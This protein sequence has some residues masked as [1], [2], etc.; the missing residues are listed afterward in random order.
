MHNSEFD[1][2]VVG[3]GS[4][5]CVLAN[6]LSADPSNRVLLIEAGGADR[7]PYIHMPAGLPKLAANLALNWNY[8]TEPQQGLAGRKLWWPRG[9]V[10]GGSSSINAMCYIRGQRED[11]DGWARQPGLEDWSFDQV[12]PWFLESED[13]SRGEDVFHDTGGPLGVSDLLHS[14]ELSHAFI[15]A[16]TEHGL[17][18]N[19]DFNGR[20]QFGAGLYQVTQRNGRRCST[21]SGFLKPARDRRNLSVVTN[22]LVERVL[23]T[24]G[25]ASGVRF[26]LGN[27]LI[28]VHAAREV[29]ICGGAINSPQ[30]LMLSGIGSARDLEQHGIE[31]VLELPGVGR[32][33]HDH[34]DI[35]TL[36]ETRGINTYD[37][38]FVQEALVGI[39][40]LFTGK[41]VGSTNAAEA[42]G[43]AMSSR[44]EDGRPDIQLHF[45]PALL[46]DHGRNK[47]GMQGMTIHACCLQ[48]RSRGGV[49][50]ASSDPAAAPRIDPRYLSD[51][52]DLPVMRDC[53]ELSR[54]IFAQQAFAP[55]RHREVFPGDDVT[56]VEGIDR[57]IRQK[58]ET[59]YH[60]VGS[61]RMGSDDMAVVDGHLRLRGID[62]LRVVD[63]SVMPTIPSGNTNA[64]V[65]MIAERA[66]AWMLDG[67]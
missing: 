29:A 8:Y 66:A 62:G 40:Y 53:V 16:A 36:V 5:G 45:V 60:P 51:D 39:E 54:S 17:P 1:F 12:L 61:C 48:P 63:A 65:I 9:K 10:L 7:S 42:G 20:E 43:F 47:L 44:A 24:K 41:G 26:R 27:Q 50:L 46:D 64:P 67:N 33:L 11:Y 22:A 59:V 55:Y 30:L 37:L 6:R 56:T 25:R 31:V 38:N 52:R 23:I 28:D 49:T 32:N 34:L 35:C 4:A 14:H 57:F 3:A 18:A 58:A 13:N 19:G 15:K 2:I 21:A